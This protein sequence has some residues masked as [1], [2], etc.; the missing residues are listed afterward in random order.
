MRHH[1]RRTGSLLAAGNHAASAATGDFFPEGIEG[2][3][4]ELAEGE[5]N[6]EDDNE[7]AFFAMRGT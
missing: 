2:V 7:R 5:V 4:E 3:L 6:A 1:H